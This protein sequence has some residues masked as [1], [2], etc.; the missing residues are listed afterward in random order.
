[1]CLASVLVDTSGDAQGYISYLRVYS[2]LLAMHVLPTEPIVSD[3]V[4][5]NYNTI[6]KFY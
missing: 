6:I 2:H 4:M 3:E 1:M 5:H